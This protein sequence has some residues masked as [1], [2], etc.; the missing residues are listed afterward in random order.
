MRGFSPWARM[1]V[2]TD[3]KV[4]I[5]TAAVAAGDGGGRGYAP[6][7]ALQGR[8]NDV[9]ESDEEGG[10][11]MEEGERSSGEGTEDL[12]RRP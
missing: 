7:A 4:A 11:H 10:G 8:E 5:P 6:R 3:L 9:R 1:A 2:V 12:H